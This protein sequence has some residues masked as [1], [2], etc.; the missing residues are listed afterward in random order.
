MRAAGLAILTV[1]LIWTDC[2]TWT[3]LFSGV[4]VIS[5]DCGGAEIVNATWGFVPKI[6][7][8]EIIITIK[9]N[10]IKHY[11]TNHNPRDVIH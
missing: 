5:T 11:R 7:D 3:S 8:S 9:F 2:P 1:Q 10:L 4:G 6:F